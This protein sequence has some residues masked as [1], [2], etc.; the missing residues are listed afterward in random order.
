MAT[1]IAIGAAAHRAATPNV[2]A[3]IAK[4]APIV[5]R[6]CGGTHPG[7][8]ERIS[9]MATPQFIADL[10]AIKQAQA[11]ASYTATCALLA[12]QFLDEVEAHE[13]ALR[14]SGEVR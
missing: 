3:E 11:T 9:I 2:A 8:E 10:E 12:E 4:T 1:G 13:T 6:E 14:G 5:S 7:H